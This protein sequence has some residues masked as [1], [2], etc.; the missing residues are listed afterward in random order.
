MTRD[1]W[2]LLVALLLA[3]VVIGF[4]AWVWADN[5]GWRDAR[6][7][8]VQQQ[9]NPGPISTAHAFIADN[10]IA[11][12]TPVQG[13]DAA[14]CIA[15]HANNEALLQRQPTAF[16]AD[17]TSCRECHLEH[18]PAGLRPIQMD[19]EALAR[20]GLRQA[21]GATTQPISRAQYSLRDWGRTQP[22][23]F[24]SKLRSYEAILNCASCHDIQDVHRSLFGQDCLACH[25]TQ[26]WSVSQFR[27]PS[28][29]STDC[30]QCHQAPPSHYMGHFHM[31]SATVA[32]KPHAQVNQCYECHQT[33]NWN[34]IKGVGYY[35][36]H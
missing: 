11:C 8:W 6:I 30:A 7:T 1:T 19:H 16:H 2:I 36:H 21:Q 31:V 34:N 10:C 5:S 24:G 17:I 14:K 15:C 32:G 27:H 22:A 12:H 18:Q 3:T 28:P 26:T 35:K 9:A 25:A 4:A 23:S 20:I 33:D 29:T 13:V